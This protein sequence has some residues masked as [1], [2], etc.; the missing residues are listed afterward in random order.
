MADKKG[1]AV[2]LG[3][4]GA[5]V[6]ALSSKEK[7]ELIRLQRKEKRARRLAGQPQTARPKR[8]RP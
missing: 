5:L 2:E 4:R 7:K 1:R 8:R 6:G 3:F